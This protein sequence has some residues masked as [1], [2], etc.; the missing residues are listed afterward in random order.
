MCV[1]MCVCVCVC[2]SV[3]VCVCIYSVYTY[4]YR[5]IYNVH[6]TLYTVHNVHSIYI[7]IYIYI[8][9]TVY[10]INTIRVYTEK[11][12]GFTHL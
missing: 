2:V 5:T 6:C 1:C 11:G 7:Y 8:Y 9:I 12:E 4:M 10:K 3:C